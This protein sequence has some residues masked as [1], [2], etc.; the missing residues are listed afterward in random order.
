MDVYTLGNYRTAAPLAKFYSCGGVM[1][2]H[3]LR[4]RPRVL[5]DASHLLICILLPVMFWRAFCISFISLICQLTPVYLVRFLFT[6]LYDKHQM[7]VYQVRR[8]A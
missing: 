4:D 3:V 2:A 8:P 5:R 6:Q 7:L 1:D